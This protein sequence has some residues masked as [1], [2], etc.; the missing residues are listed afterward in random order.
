MSDHSQIQKECDILGID[1]IDNITIKFVTA[2]YKRRAKLVHPDKGGKDCDFQELQEAYR[3]VVKYLENLKKEDFEET[4]DDQEKEFF[5]KHNMVKECST[6][7]VVYIEEILASKWTNVL[8]RHLSFQKRD[9][10]RAIFKSGKLTITI[11]EKPKKDP[12][13]KIHIQ[14]GDQRANLEFIIEKLSLFYNEVNEA[15]LEIQQIKPI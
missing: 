12:R 3:K 2:K 6:S 13:P 11:Y 5:M 1:D 10:C 4:D 7:I 14:S 8:A 15:R 9:K